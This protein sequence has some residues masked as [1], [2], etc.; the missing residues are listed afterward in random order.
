MV[1]IESLTEAKV[2][3]GHPKNLSN[4]KTRVSRAGISGNSVTFDAATVVAQLEKGHEMIEEAMKNNQEVLVLCEKEIYKQ[5]IELLAEKVGFHY[6]NHK[7]PAGVLTN[8]DTLLIRIKSLQDMRSYLT[9]ESY[10]SL[11]KKEQNMKK[12]ELEKIEMVYKGVSNLRKKPGLVIIVDGQMM[13]KFV[14]EV[15]STQT[16]AVILSS[17][18]FDIH[19]NTHLIMG[20]VN[21]QRSIDL[22]MHV[23]MNGIQLTKATSKTSTPS[24]SS[25]K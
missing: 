9:S 25:A 22:I 20:N 13:H 6:M 16:P 24:R 11:T 23:L 21:S 19:T 7:I 5:E 4:P 18:N 1:T 17:S 12:R 3:V 14:K 8:F 15:I 2:L 10:K